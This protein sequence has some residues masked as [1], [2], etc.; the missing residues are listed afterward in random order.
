MG[1]E[2][3]EPR[4]HVP[5][6]L[7]TGLSQLIRVYAGLDIACRK[8]EVRGV[9]VRTYRGALKPEIRCLTVKAVPIAN[10]P[11]LMT[12]TTGLWAFQPSGFAG[13]GYHAMRSVAGGACGPLYSLLPT[14][15]MDTAGGPIIQQVD[16]ALTTG[17][18]DVRGIDP[19]SSLRSGQD[20]MTAMTVATG[21]CAD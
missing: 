16:M 4:R 1:A 10:V 18:G 19:G 6:A 11:P 15:A 14:S 5:M 13:R 17:P 12:S 2:I 7:P 8:I 3:Q 21:G 9:A 20:I